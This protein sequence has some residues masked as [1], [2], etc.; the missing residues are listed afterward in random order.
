MLTIFLIFLVV[1]LAHCKPSVNV[2]ESEVGIRRT[3]TLICILPSFVSFS[4][5][6]FC[7]QAS[8]AWGFPL[9][10]QALA[11]SHVIAQQTM[12]QQ[13]GFGV[14]YTQFCQTFTALINHLLAKL[15][16]G[17]CLWTLLLFASPIWLPW[18]LA[19]AEG[20]PIGT[21]HDVACGNKQ[22]SGQQKEQGWD[23][24]ASY[25]QGGQGLWLD[26]AEAIRGILVRYSGLG[27]ACS[28]SM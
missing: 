20:C 6:Y 9:F 15:T 14:L 17:N 24:S 3:D 2:I 4:G 10:F 19:V 21:E 16:L 5:Q 7:F 1:S 27:L 22:L 12:V 23:R 8:Q 11:L 13:R 28:G 25:L 26:P 18:I